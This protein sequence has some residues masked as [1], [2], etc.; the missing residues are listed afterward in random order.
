MRPIV[1]LGFFARLSAASA[2][3]GLTETLKLG[4]GQDPPLG[5]ADKVANVR[6][7]FN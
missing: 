7:L 5:E 2:E 6:S 3:A 4:L 1:R